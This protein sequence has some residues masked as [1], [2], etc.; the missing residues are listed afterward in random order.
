MIFTAPRTIFSNPRKIWPA[1][2]IEGFNRLLKT[3]LATAPMALSNPPTALRTSLKSSLVFMKFRTSW[4]YWLIFR[5]ARAAES[6]PTALKT[7]S[8][9][10]ANAILI[11]L[12]K[13]AMFSP[14]SFVSLVVLPIVSEPCLNV[15]TMLST[16]KRPCF[17]ASAMSAPARLP[18]TCIARLILSVAFNFDLSPRRSMTCWRPFFGLP[19]ATSSESREP[20]NL[21]VG[22]VR[23]AKASFR[24]GTIVCVFTPAF[25]NVANIAAASEM[26]NPR[27]RK[28]EP[29]FWMFSA[30]SLTSP[31]PF[32]DSLNRPLSERVCFFTGTSQSWKARDTDLMLPSRSVS[33]I[34]D[35]FSM[36]RDIL[37][38]GLPLRSSRVFSPAMDFPTV[39][40]SSGTELATERKSAFSLSKRLP[41]APVPTRI[42]S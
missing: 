18:N 8:A 22:A 39:S 31:P 37:R 32:C 27:F 10:G 35:K 3:H 25:S 26:S 9:K 13:I 5:P 38:S 20:F 28:G 15:L 14:K 21:S 36:F 6:L 4:M 23:F 42:L 29:N 41:V 19:I 30:S 17:T 12:P 7:T 40:K 11:L 24:P 2:L 33:V 34:R 1:D 16:L